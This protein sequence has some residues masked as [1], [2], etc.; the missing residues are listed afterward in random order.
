MSRLFILLGIGMIFNFNCYSQ[1]QKAIFLHHSVGRNMYNE[2][3]V[4]TY[5]TDYNAQHNT[6]IQLSEKFYPTNPWPNDNNP[7]DYWALWVNGQCSNNDVNIQCLT[8]LAA[9]YQ[10]VIFKHCYTG[11]NILADLGTPLVSSNRQSIE[12]YKLQYRVLRAELDKYPNTKFLLWTLVP[13]HQLEATNGQEL[14]VNQFVQWVKTQWL[15]EDGKSHS[16]I[17]LFDVFSQ[18]AK[19]SNSGINQGDGKL[20]CLKDI[21]EKNQNDSHPNT[22]ANETVGPLFAKRI[23][24]VLV[25]TATNVSNQN[26]S[27]I[28]VFSRKGSSLIAYDCQTVGKTPQS[29]FIYSITGEKVGETSQIASP[30]GYIELNRKTGIFIVKLQFESSVH[31]VKILL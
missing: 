12:N 15:S 31:T 2:G 16:N 29:I 17:Y 5:I 28:K 4:A 18:L 26:S 3:N 9:N 19:T 22:L 7:Y 24:E 14:L 10:L 8:G 1:V 30:Q 6:Q 20:Y 27:K 11:A 13:E 23:T 21:Y 25:G